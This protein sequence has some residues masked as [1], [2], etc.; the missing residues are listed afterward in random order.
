MRMIG[1]V[2]DAGEDVAA[3]EAGDDVERARVRGV[4]EDEPLVDQTGPADAE[5]LLVL[6]GEEERRRPG[7]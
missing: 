1:E 7:W 4:A 5:V 2:A 6:A 3:V